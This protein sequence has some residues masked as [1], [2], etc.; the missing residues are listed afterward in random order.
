MDYSITALTPLV[1]LSF[2]GEGEGLVLKGFHPFNLPPLTVERG[3]DL[4][5]GASKKGEAPLYKIFPF[6]LSRGRG[7][8]R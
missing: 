2:Q 6:P 4:V 5:N 7:Y 8:R 3:I 1:P